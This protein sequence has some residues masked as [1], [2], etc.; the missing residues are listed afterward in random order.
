MTK[1]FPVISSILSAKEIGDFI[2]TRYQLNPKL[3]C[4]LFRTGM[5]HTYILSGSEEKYVLRL[6]TYNWRTLN[7][8]KAELQLL[9]YLHQ[10]GIQVSLP[11]PDKNENLIQQIEALEGIRYAVLFSFASGEKKRFIKDKTAATIG[12]IMAKFHQVT[13]DKKIDRISYT[14][15]TLLEKPYQNLKSYFSEQ[16]PEMRFIEEYIKSFSNVEFEDMQKGSVHMDIW[17]DNMAILNDID[18][19]L[20]DFDFCG[21]GCQILDVGY[22]C[23]QLFHIESDKQQFLLKTQSFLKGYHTNRPL[24]KKEIDFIPRA[25]VLVFLF[26]LG[27]QAQR[28]DWSNIFL[29]ENYVKM[30]MAKIQ[31]WINF[32]QENKIDL[33]G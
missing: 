10:K 27:I 4:R 25:G 26:Y 14:K 18:I 21:N 32:C 11:I 20:F 6:Y 33:N 16:L 15:N 31:S 12:L 22:F 30:Y 28:Y 13:V 5:N 23:K 7:E 8:I 17:Y 1:T 29:S 9:L 19:T 24:S 2:K 3:Q